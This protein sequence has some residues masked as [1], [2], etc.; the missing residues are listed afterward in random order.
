M[1][2]Q[3]EKKQLP[4]NQALTN[5]ATPASH[6]N[7]STVPIMDG[8]PE[9]V[10]QKKL[11]EQVN[12]SVR[13]NHVNA[14]QQTPVG[15]PFAP[16]QFKKL[17]KH[18]LNVVGEFHTE[19]SKRLES[20]KLIAKTEVGGGFWREDEFRTRGMK[21]SETF[22]PDS[23]DD[24]RP[25]GDALYVRIAESIQYVQDAKNDFHK[26]WKE[27][28]VENVDKTELPGMKGEFQKML[29]KC[30]T[31][32]GAAREL[33]TK[34]IK[35]DEFTAIDEAE[36]ISVVA[37]RHMAEPTWEL[38][39]K[40][41]EF[42]KTNPLDVI[43]GSEFMSNMKKFGEEVD[44]MAIHASDVGG[45]DLEE[46]SKKRSQAMDA[47]AEKGKDIVGVWKI[48]DDHVNHIKESLEIGHQKNY[49]LIG[50]E[51]FNSEYKQLPVWKDGEM[52]KQED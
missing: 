15:A 9:S 42:W 50:R 39:L 22:I 4:K 43:I 26:Y 49:N 24:V 29:V 10:A 7:E 44:A 38:F 40:M 1:H 18:R 35:N 45:R 46:T 51:E 21:Q 5:S 13:T 2:T 36:R 41:A 48:G 11:Q 25:F 32:L 33:F 14:L 28:D 23:E 19:S 8:R 17:E 37:I 27:W 12:N 16:F 34:L 30:K 20:E 31:H 52:V 3:I 47:G 6:G